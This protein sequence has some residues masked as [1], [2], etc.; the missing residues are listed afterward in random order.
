MII[1]RRVLRPQLIAT[2]VGIV[3][4]GILGVGWLFN[5]VL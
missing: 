1:L 2:F 5:A 4:I 3:A